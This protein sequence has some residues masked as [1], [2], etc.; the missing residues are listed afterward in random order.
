MKI[1][2][3]LV[4][5]RPKEMGGLE[6]YVRN[7]FK[8]FAAIND[9]ELE[10][11]IFLA[12][13]NYCY[14][15]EFET[16][17]HF[18][19]VC[20]PVSSKIKIF[21]MLYQM[22][23]LDR[24][25]SELGCVCLYLPTPI[26]PLLK[27]RVPVIV[28]IHDLQFLHFPSYA[29]TLQRMKYK[30]CWSKCISN[31]ARIITISRYTEADVLAHFACAAGKTI[32]IYNPIDIEQ[33]ISNASKPR[34]GFAEDYLYTI[35]S[36]APHKHNE[37]L[38]EILLEIHRSGEWALP[39]KLVITGLREDR[40]RTFFDQVCNLDLN[41]FIA[42]TGYI[43]NKD[44]DSL[45]KNAYAFIFVS[46]FEGFGM[47]PV[48]AMI[49]GTPAITT[50]CASLPEVTNNLANY[51]D[52]PNSAKEWVQQLRNVGTSSRINYAFPEYSLATVAE[53]FASLIKEIASL[54]V[55]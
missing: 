5:L 23:C 20:C 24:K 15:Q 54:G 27:G 51:V 21:A 3:N 26:Y 33:N 48:E 46:Q 30:W 47:P 35:T 34:L 12:S 36:S 43:N 50:R 55:L 32:T 49:L 18:H 10:F 19:Y 37:M 44:R 31:S 14:V 28:T 8:G 38:L 2:I 39:K 45:I 29:N 53:K 11:I 52:D 7:L 25:A 22:F 42:T 9:P 40:D 1:G 41:D 4:W 16:N 17:P 6:S 13:D